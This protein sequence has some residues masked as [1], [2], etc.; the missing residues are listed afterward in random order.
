MDCASIGTLAVIDDRRMLNEPFSRRLLRIIPLVVFAAT[1]CGGGS[2]RADDGPQPPCGNVPIPPYPGLENSPS[3]RAW[4][5][6]ASGRNWIPPACT[7]WTD[8]GFTTLVVT[9]A[10]FR[11]ASGIEGFLRNIGA[12]SRLAGMRYWSTTHKRWQTF[13]ISAHAMSEA[14][15]DRPRED[16]SPGE[17]AEGRSLYYQQEDNLSGKVNYRMRIRSAS[18]DRLI[19][20]TENTSTMRNLLLPMYRPGGMQTI[21]F[22]DRE[23]RDVWRYYSILRTSR[24]ASRLT[25]GREASFINRAVAFYRHLAGIPTDKE[26]P[27]A[28]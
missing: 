18:P 23:S 3:V 13:I 28:P 4:D 19:F 14:A 26:P 15:G 25:A 16:F 12:I 1:L 22:L 8:S 17:M 27:A 20:D 2:S 11:H 6:A 9:V 10:R 24:D 7:G 21:T 5:R